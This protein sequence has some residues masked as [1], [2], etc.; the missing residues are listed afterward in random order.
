MFVRTSIDR[1]HQQAVDTGARIVISCGFA[2][3]P[4]DLNVYQLYRRAQGDGA[5]ELCDTPWCF[6]PSSRAGDRRHRRLGIRVDAHRV[7]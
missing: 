2:S 6:A 3:I 4:S 7:Q 5:G 1:Y